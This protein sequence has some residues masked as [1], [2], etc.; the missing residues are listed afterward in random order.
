METTFMFDVN[1]TLLDSS[2]LDSLFE[3]AFGNGTEMRNTWFSHLIERAWACTMSGE[4][5]GFSELAAIALDAVTREQ[6]KSSIDEREKILHRFAHMPAHAE[7]PAA[8]AH[9]HAQGA[10]IYALTNS[11]K[12]SAEEALEAAGLRT[13]LT[14]V[15]SVETVRAF[16]P[17]PHVYEMAVR[18]AHDVPSKTW[19]ISAHWW[20]CMGAARQGWK[21]ALV[22]REPKALEPAMINPAVSSSSLLGVVEVLAPKE[23]PVP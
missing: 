8:L 22:V 4:Y 17:D 5:R 7:A 16:K 19:L 18:A 3:S 20:D 12:A 1:E 10:K 13:F 21:T 23:S 15:L 6:N 14:D 11:S 9:L 2:S